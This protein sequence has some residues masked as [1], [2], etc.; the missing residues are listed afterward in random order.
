MNFDLSV[1]FR[2]QYLSALIFD[3]I[4]LLFAYF[5]PAL[6]HLSGLPL[7]YAD[8]MRLVIILAIVITL[9]VNAYFL[10]FTLPLFSFIVSSHPVFLKSLIMSIELLFNIW[11][12]YFLKKNIN[13][14]LISAFLSIFVSKLLYYLLKYFLISFAF[15]KSELFSTPV[16]IQ[17]ISVL[18]FSL[19]IFA[20]V[21]PTPD[22]GK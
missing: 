17:L 9:P 11:M 22:D 16:I 2:K 18:V 4:A 20:F 14:I 3:I 12:F 6:S 10:A 15:L 21:K 19:L 1:S 7:Y 13:S 5:I 8:P